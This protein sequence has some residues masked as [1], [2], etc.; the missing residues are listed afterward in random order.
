MNEGSLTV[1][2]EKYGTALGDFLVRFD[3]EARLHAYELGRRAMN[4]DAGLLDIVTIHHL[5]LRTFLAHASNSSMTKTWLSRAAEFL[6]ECLAPFEMSQ[7]GYREANNELRRLIGALE[8]KNDEVSRANRELEAFSYSVAH[9]LRAPLRAIDGFSS[10][11]LRDHTAELDEAGLEH[12]RLV[13]SSAQRM[14]QLIDDL[15]NLSRFSRAEV[16]RLTF[17]LGS[18]A[19]DVMQRIRQEDPERPFEFVV[20]DGIPPVDADPGLLD[21][22]LQNLLG[23]AWK[24]TRRCEKA[25]VEFGWDPAEG[26]YFV[27]D[28]GAGFDMAY[29][30]KLFQVF[31]RLHSAAEFEG[32]GV[33]LAI[34]QRIVERHG[35][36]IWVDARKDQGATFFFTIP[37]ATTSISPLGSAT[38][39]KT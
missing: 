14:A 10:I 15:L 23:N 2:A 19:R 28:N 11:L 6:G 5:S 34:V 22:V 31:H 36:R 8:Q 3:E 1:L 29:A 20:E 38:L 33:G 16:H 13:R 35:G 4:E 25:H 26:A 7:R 17:D 9:D 24:Y 12:L 18:L 37:G 21:A 30:N 32:T 27:R 39:G